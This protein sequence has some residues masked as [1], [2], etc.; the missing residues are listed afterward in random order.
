MSFTAADCTLGDEENENGTTLSE[1]ELNAVILLL[2]SLC[3]AV[4][5]TADGDIGE[6]TADCAIVLAADEPDGE[7]GIRPS[8]NELSL[9]VPNMFV[10]GFSSGDGVLPTE[11][12]ALSG[13]LSK[14]GLLTS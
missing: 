3:E 13:A 11:F 4:L 12:L 10:N 5:S 6:L 14:M 9:F 2:F 1:F 8:G 7:T